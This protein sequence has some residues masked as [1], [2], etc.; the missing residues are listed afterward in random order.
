MNTLECRS[1]GVH[2]QITE[3]PKD[4]RKPYGVGTECK[5][6]MN[7]R[8]KARRRG[9]TCT[10]ERSDKYWECVTCGTVKELTE[11]HFYVVKSRLTKYDNM[12]RICRNAYHTTLRRKAHNTPAQL[13]Q[14]ERN[15]ER[16]KIKHRLLKVQA[17]I[18][19]GSVCTNCGLQ[20]NG[21]NAMVFDF[22]HID[23]TEKESQALQSSRTKTLEAVK[24]ELDKCT[25]LCANC[26]R[27][28]HSSEY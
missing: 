28:V 27:T 8:E 20:Y 6:C 15:N 7:L 25:L 23:P 18:Y 21:K 22:H 16:E 4:K 26:H 11:E 14:R 24:E 13:E 1:C 9:I 2:K 5:S 3:F 12:C 17:I 19:K 10:K